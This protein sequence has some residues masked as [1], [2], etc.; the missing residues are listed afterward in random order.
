MRYGFLMDQTKCI[1]CHACT[2]ACKAEHDVPLGSFRTW[3]EYT[4]TGTFP[5]ASRHFQ[6]NRCNHCDNAPCP[7]FER[8]FCEIRTGHGL[9][10]AAEFVGTTRLL[11]ARCWPAPLHPDTQEPAVFRYSDPLAYGVAKVVVPLVHSNPAA[12]PQVTMC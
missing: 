4:E 9:A 6:V 2:V 7:E 12:I 5:N 8:S 1:G 3:V 11:L 10:G